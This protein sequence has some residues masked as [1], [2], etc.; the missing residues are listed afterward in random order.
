M[1][2]NK[3]MKILGREWTS[4][5]L[6]YHVKKYLEDYEESA[7][8]TSEESDVSLVDWDFQKTGKI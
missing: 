6:E 1:E 8:G 7:S 4:E 3:D 5:Y 2:V